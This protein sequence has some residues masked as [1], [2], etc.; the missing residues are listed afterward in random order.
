V[1]DVS[2][3]GSLDVSGRAA[4]ILRRCELVFWDFDGVIKD[5]VAVKTRAFERLFSPF[6]DQVVSRVR[7]HH[8]RNGGMS[9]LE[10]F[11]LYLHWAKQDASPGEVARYCGLFREAV[12]Q[13]VIDSPWVPGV[14]EYLAAHYG[15]QFFVLITGTPQQEIED[16]VH[17]LGITAWFQE[18][19]GA[20]SAKAD[21][22]RA[23]LGRPE[24]AG[25]SAIMIGDATADMQAAAANGVEFLLRRTPLNR[26]LQCTH[27]GPQCEDFTAH[28]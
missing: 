12:C 20:P 17:A 24:H 11:P 2:A 15:S 28:E 14:R 5:S 10:K 27:R 18:I 9:R 16:I 1:N 4:A 13:S 19:Y 8:E 21:V 6:G 26:D 25:K 3:A 22:I 7:E 23:V